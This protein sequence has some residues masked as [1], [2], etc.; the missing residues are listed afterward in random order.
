MESTAKILA[1]IIAGLIIILAAAMTIAGL[2]YPAGFDYLGITPES[3]YSYD[4]KISSSSEIKDVAMF[5]PLPSSRDE[6]PIGTVISGGFGYGLKDLKP[7]IFGAKDSVMLK[8]SADKIRD[9]SFGAVSD[10][11]AIINTQNYDSGSLLLSP[12]LNFS[13]NNRVSGYQTY[14]YAKYDADP[15]CRVDI[16]VT[17]K[18]ENKWSFLTQKEN[19]YTNYAHLTLTGP[20][21]GWYEAD[22]VAEYKNGDYPVSI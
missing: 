11:G 1:L 17:A 7:E 19:S 16:F 18:G 8:I 4:V 15:D 12:V 3:T 14:I 10:A 22:A 13:D 5:L 21:S 6:S 20:K 2:F 9:A